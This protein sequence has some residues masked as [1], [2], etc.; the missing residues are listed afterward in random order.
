MSISYWWSSDRNWFCILADNGVDKAT[1]SLTP[2]EAELLATALST[3]SDAVNESAEAE[4]PTWD[5]EDEAYELG[6][7]Y[8]YESAVQDFD[9]ATG[10]DGEFKGSTIPSETVD[11]ETMKQRVISRICNESAEAPR[12]P[13]PDNR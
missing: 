5:A 10:G 13:G 12:A 9:I 11:V 7:R 8:G 3:P 6:K 1:V 4:F 2:Q